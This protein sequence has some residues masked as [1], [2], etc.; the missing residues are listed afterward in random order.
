LIIDSVV[1]SFIGLLVASATIHESWRMY[2]GTG[3][4]AKTDGKALSALHCFSALS[5]GRKILSMKVTSSSSNDNFGCIHGI[6]FFSTV[7]VVVGHTWIIGAYK[8]MNPR[9]VKTV[10][11]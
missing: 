9:A 8:T 3:Y 1:L 2:C 10:R 4:D 5:N 7:W 6:R 11:S